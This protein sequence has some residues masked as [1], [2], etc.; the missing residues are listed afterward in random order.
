MR[1]LM[2]I[3]SLLLFGLPWIVPPGA[4]AG[5]A[6]DGPGPCVYEHAD[7]NGCRYMVGGYAGDLKQERFDDCPDQNID[8]KISSFWNPTTDRWA[9]LHE[10]PG[11]R[12]ASFCIRPGARGNIPASFNDKASSITAFIGS[13]PSKWC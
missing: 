1:R 5:M 6:C 7:Q 3:A 9:V 12:G 8:D 2:L 13:K 11:Q 4:S 10:H